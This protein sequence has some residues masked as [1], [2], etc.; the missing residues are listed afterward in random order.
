MNKK[1]QRIF[2]ALLL[3]AFFN[4]AF[5]PDA[6]ADFWGSAEAAAIW[7]YTINKME[8]SVQDTILANL[9][10]A[11]L[12]IV[13]ARLMSLLG[14]NKS[15]TP[16]V[17][18]FI[19]SDWKQFIYS[20]AMKYSNQ[21]TTDFFRGISSGAP[22]GIMTNVINPAQKA[23]NT[24]YWGMQPNLQNYVAG[25]DASKIFTSG[26]TSNPWAAWQAA[27]QPQNDLA[28]TYLRAAGFQQAAY[29]QQAAASKAEGVAGQG[30][31]GKEATNQGPVRQATASNG[32]QV[33]V[34]AGSNYQGQS[35]TTP[36]SVIGNLMNQ[37]N[38]M[39]VQMLTLARTVPEVVTAMVNQMISQ[40][41]QKGVTQM[42]SPSGS[43]GG[44]MSTSQMTSQ[45]TNQAQAL[46]QS[47]VRSV[48]SPN[49]LFG[50]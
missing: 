34:P 23:V 28:F 45:M 32:N 25:G 2:L 5:A 47:G 4:M 35:I 26:A 13:Q 3:F 12:R 41:I 8:K 24:D 31:K 29:N 42:I 17:T 36:G 44:G 38:G 27:A 6:H 21:V 16:G 20:S 30:V 37:V 46:I 40:I 43:G 49:M 19:I 22:S 15:T 39:P 9:K 48:A 18:G 14:S 33:S 7:T 10:M 11:A 50:H 1:I